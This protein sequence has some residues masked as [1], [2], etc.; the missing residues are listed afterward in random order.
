MA[1]TNKSTSSQD[2]E[3]FISLSHLQSHLGDITKELE[4]GNR[5]TLIRYSK[6]MGVILSYSEY[7][8]LINQAKSHNPT[9]RIC[10]Y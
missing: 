5:F 6:P 9:C 3:R 2:R 10:K 4:A 1:K 8:D 7:Q